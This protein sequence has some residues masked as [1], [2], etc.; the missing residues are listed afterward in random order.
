METTGLILTSMLPHDT[1]EVREIELSSGDRLLA[2]TDGIYEVLDPS[3]REFERDS[4]AIFLEESRELP[5][6][7]ALDQLLDRVRVHCAGRPFDDD[8]TV[9][10][11]ERE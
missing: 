2:F 1:T 7:Q 9:L 5:L 3:G 4:L 8:A 10:L 6:S 11:I